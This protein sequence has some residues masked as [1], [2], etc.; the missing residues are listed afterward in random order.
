MRWPGRRH[1]YLA[2]AGVGCLAIAAVVIAAWPEARR[3]VAAEA[4]PPRQAPTAPVPVPVPPALHAIWPVAGWVIDT[5]GAPIE[6]VRITTGGDLVESDAD[7][8]FRLPPL[9]S[10]TRALRLDGDH[11]FAAE[12]ER[13][14]GEPPARIMLARRAEL[15][16]RVTGDGAPVA[17]ATVHLSDGSGPSATT[18]LTGDDGVAHFADLLP[19]PYEVW[20][21]DE[22][23]A[24]PL[25]RTVLPDDAPV[26][27]ALA[28]AA[29]VE[30]RVVAAGPVPAGSTVALVPIELDHATRVVTVDATGGFAADAVPRGR[31]RALAS[32]PGHVA[33]DDV[34]V[35]VAGA[36]AT[37]EIRVERGGTVTGVVVDGD[38][39]PVRG[40]TVV[41]R[42]HGEAARELDDAERPATR[43]R[44]VHPLAG[45]RQ[46]PARDGRRFG[47]ARHGARPAECGR[48]H[49]G[50]DLGFRRGVVVHAAADG[51]IAAVYTEIRREAGRYVAIEHA[52]GLRTYYMHLDDIR[53]DLEVGQR[54]HAGDPLGTVGRTGVIKSG[55][56]LHFALAQER[57]GRTWY[58]DPEPIL[59]HAVVLPAPRPF[60]SAALGDVVVATGAA[61]AGAPPASPAPAR[62]TTDDQGRFRIDGV[63]PGDYVA[64]AFHRELAPGLSDDF[65]VRAGAETGGVRIA[66]APGVVV[67]GRVLGLHGA[68]AGARVVAE[69]GVGETSHKVATAFTDAHGEFTLRPLAGTVTLSVSAAGH[70][71]AERTVELDRAGPRRREDF[72]LVLEDA[73]L[74]AD[75]VG[76]D[77]GAAGG[78]TVR[79]VDGP[80]RRRATITDPQGRFTLERLARGTY[81]V[82]L[83]SPEHPP[84]RAT[85][86]TDRW[87]QL[88]LA[89]GGAV[90]I[91]LRDAHT[92]APLADVRV[93]A[94]GPDDHAARPTT[95][96]DGVAVARGLVAGR[97]TVR[98]RVPGYVAGER[99]VEVRPGRT[100]IELRLELA[101]GATLAGVVRDAD[102]RR[103][104][105]AVVSVGEATTRAD[106]D[107]E[108]RLADVPTGAVELVAE[109][110]GARAAVPLELRPGDEIV[111]L[112]VDL[113]E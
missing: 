34:D 43:L 113:P 39:E 107:G 3:P 30:G 63:A 9:V 33:P 35:T 73:R 95:G 74:F 99:T 62:P 1:T 28:R 86:S 78:V 14:A 103:A 111:T 84:L 32:V 65:E 10:G 56:H 22:R 47:A 41:L 77:G 26:E 79:V 51:E 8:A 70:G 89:Q 109:R 61:E 108:F 83:T 38:G 64:T 31:W 97:W 4:A 5:T 53:P 96:G 17:G 104:A 20:A 40:A 93:D 7:G 25:A 13:R 98:A 29:R 11:V 54:V 58:I 50:V 23:R 19:G 66:L 71:A 18:A 94:D 46:L 36:T 55:P 37:V 85:L 91:D 27:L 67:H 72:D 6:G 106:A 60:E 105:G 16:V 92:G 87:A 69:E 59:R 81:E 2:I 12:V 82:E 76:P 48:G 49:C 100:P 110:D 45:E 44:W 112:K 88:R 15:E 52:G 75:V 42:G 24:S 21:A 102:G 57:E 68:V 101:R 80:T 90:R